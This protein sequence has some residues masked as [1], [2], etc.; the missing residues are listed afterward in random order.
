MT[1]KK[2]KIVGTLVPISALR[3]KAQNPKDFGTFQTGL[4]F[5]DWLQKTNQN[6]W[7]LLPLHETQLEKDSK[8]KH[9]P[10]PYKGY[11]IGLD[12]KYLSSKNSKSEIRN[13]KQIQNSND[14][15][16]KVLQKFIFENK[17]WIEDYALFCALRDQFGTDD[18]RDWT[19]DLRDRK[20]Q[21]L[22]IWS[23]KNKK[24]ID[25]HILEQFFLHKEYKELKDK[26]GKLGISLFGDLPFYLSI[27]SPLVWANK[28]LFQIDNKGQMKFVPGQP[29]GPTAHFGRQV[30]GHP[31]YKWGDKNQT[32]K[33][34]QFWELRLKYLSKLF[35]FI[36]FDHAK[37]LFK[38]AVINPKNPN[39]DAFRNGPGSTAFERLINY[40]SDIGLKFY[41]E[42]SGEKVGELRESLNRLRIPG[43]KIFR[44]ALDEKLRKIHAEYADIAHYQENTVAYTTTHDSE[45]LLSYLRKFEPFEKQLLADVSKVKYSKNDREFARNIRD[46]I[47]HSTA[48]IVIIPIQDWL[49]STDRINIPGTEKEKDDPNWRYE[50]TI[51]VEELK[52]V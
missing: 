46:K 6:A 33:V 34:L 45:T 13:S 30:W 14:K 26:A 1:S 47:I 4:H 39:E 48:K 52:I 7:Q 23:K 11:G 16:S 41:A 8:T 19:A 32:E 31:L 42:D 20:K 44:F 22:D 40:S 21:T 5:L 43:I 17:D 36:R 25:S 27:K 51:P 3:S 15:S 24:Q 10:S 28:D 12:P 2:N 18:W 9:V 35:D 50:L 29:D 37:A 38:Y 49:L